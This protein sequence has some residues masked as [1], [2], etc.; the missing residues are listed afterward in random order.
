MK[1]FET[2]SKPTGWKKGDAAGTRRRKLLAW[3]DKRRTRHNRLIQA[4]RWAQA[5]ANVT[6]DTETARKAKADAGYF[7]ERAREES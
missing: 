6:R 1:W 7:Y 5:L 3:T 2:R 4:A